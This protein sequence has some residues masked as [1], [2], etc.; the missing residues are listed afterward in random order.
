ML[1]TAKGS[2]RFLLM[3]MILSAI[4]IS[5][6]KRIVKEIPSDYVIHDK[7]EF[8]C[9]PDGYLVISKANYDEKVNQLVNCRET[10]FLLN[11]R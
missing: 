1:C 3:I 5:C 10:I 4:S 2:K 9:V 8:P 7:T 6:S 11:D